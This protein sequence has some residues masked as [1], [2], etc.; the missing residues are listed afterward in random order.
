MAKRGVFKK[1]I[2]GLFEENNYKILDYNFE[3]G[4]DKVSVECPSGH[5]TEINYYNFKQGRRC[6]YC[7]QT[8]KY[9]Y[10]YVYD[11]FIKNKCKLISRKYRS[12]K[13][14]LEYVCS[15][16]RRSETTF[17]T[18]KNQ[19]KYQCPACSRVSQTNGKK[20]DF[21][22]VLFYFKNFEMEVITKKDEYFDARTR[23]AV[24][25][26]CGN[27]FNISY[28]V[29]KQKKN[30]YCKDCASKKRYE[31]YKVRIKKATEYDGVEVLDVFKNDKNDYSL[32]LKC[33]CGDIFEVSYLTW[34]ARSN[35][36]CNKC[37]RKILSKLNAKY[38][39]DYVRERLRKADWT[40][41]S[42]E[43]KSASTKMHALCENG[44]KTEF[45]FEHF[46]RGDRCRK[47]FTENNK[48]EN[49]HNWKGGITS[50]SEKVRKS[51][52]YKKWREQVYKKDGYTCQKCGSKRSDLCAHHIR[53]FS[54]YEDLRFDIG[55]GITLCEKCHSPNFTGSFHNKYGTKN[56]TKEQLEEF[57]LE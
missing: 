42:T 9:T 51:P 31:E 29:F 46:L 28:S 25:C 7:S 32:K 52:E 5:R 12:C 8:V 39:I 48:G 34:K 36:V 21:D 55:N 2:I 38:D 14:K 45:R 13:D 54:H 19:S 56:N 10:D 30:K 15:C 37:Y 43:Y 33:S 17:D 24:R 3:K 4:K 53:N 26:F 16:G 44:H 23:L 11:F 20:V 27:S 35:K 41:V 22:E 49:H 1:D 47:C 6:R 18:F 57:L 50:E 40:L